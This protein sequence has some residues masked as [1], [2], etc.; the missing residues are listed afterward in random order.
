MPDNKN[1]LDANARGLHRNLIALSRHVD[2]VR[3]ERRST[4][5]QELAKA[6][7]LAQGMS[8]LS[9]EDT[10]RVVMSQPVRGSLHAR[11]DGLFDAFV[12][13]KEGKILSV[14][15]LERA[16]SALLSS[17]TMLA[18]HAMLMQ[19]SA[20]IDRL[21]GS[22]DEVLARMDNARIGQINAALSYL[23]EQSF[24]KPEHRDNMLRNA[25]QKIDEVFH[26]ALQDISY[27]IGNVPPPP[28]WNLTRVVWDTSGKTVEKLDQA[29]ASM[30]IALLCLDAI[31]KTQIQLNGEDGAAGIMLNRV[32]MLLDLPLKQA[33]SLARRIPVTC[34]EDRRDRFW[35]EAHHALAKTHEKLAEFLDDERPVVT[36][37]EAT[38]AELVGFPKSEHRGSDSMPAGPTKAARPGSG[39][40]E[41]RFRQ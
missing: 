13:S 3:D 6:T 14:A 18:G 10:Y 2:I 8:N 20:Q 38:G 31:G 12:K 24:Y 40:E 4:T 28:A 30:R 37:I 32:S 27:G 22:V 17:A 39:R 41:P 19:I 29:A 5:L 7:S 16:G 26:A 35:I 21:Q 23:S 25:V 9:R 33:E 34:D 15:R 11:G 1:L 36:R